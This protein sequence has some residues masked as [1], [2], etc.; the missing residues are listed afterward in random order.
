[1]KYYILFDGRA[2][3][4]VD[5]AS[6]VEAVGNTR[7]EVRRALHFWRAHDVVL[8]EYD[9]METGALKRGVVL[10]HISEGKGTLMRRCGK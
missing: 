10:G 3:S 4:N 9:V 1:M 8:V 6:V 5:N 7:G 2:L